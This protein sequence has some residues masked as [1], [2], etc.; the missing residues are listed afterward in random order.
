MDSN[1]PRQHEPALSIGPRIGKWA[2]RRDDSSLASR[3]RPR[4]ARGLR[5]RVFDADTFDAADAYHPDVRD[6]GPPDVAT[7]CKGKDN[8]W[9]C[10][11]NG[12]NGVAPSK[13]DL[14]ECRDASVYK[15]TLCDAGCLAYPNGVPDRCNECPGM[16]DG[17][18][19]GSQ[20]PSGL[21]DNATTLVL[22]TQGVGTVEQNCAPKTCAP[23]PGTAKCQ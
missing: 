7:L 22:C 12:L 5:R 18:Y 8:G 13:D 3:P 1:V 14:V 2:G 21:A 11:Y 4:G 9:Y 23:G 19:C 20:F 6:A 10:G 15:L 17:Y 16:K